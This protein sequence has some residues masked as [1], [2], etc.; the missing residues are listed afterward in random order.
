ML[1]ITSSSLVLCLSVS[2]W[3][4]G[5]GDDDGDGDGNRDSGAQTDS[6][7][8]TDAGGGLPGMDAGRDA[9]L[10]SGS[11]TPPPVDSGT[12]TDAGHVVTDAGGS[13]DAGTPTSYSVTLTSAQ[14]APPCASAATGATGTAS[15]VVS[16]DNSKIDVELAYSGLSGAATAAHIHAGAI[17][18]AGPF[19]LPF[20]A[21]LT[22]PIK[23]TFT[24][25][26]Y[27]APSGA[28]ATFAAFVT[29][30][31]T[32]GAY[33]NVHTAA[34]GAGEIRGQIQ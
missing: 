1:K 34:C 4:I 19:V 16:A 14:G 22:S 15:V 12:G 3:L 11:T 7:T 28:P 18:V 20:A 24:A 30:L 17:G 26:D 33:L 8:H 5:C 10:D 27:A 31:K 21:P 32:G 13:I 29:S 25:A 9:G 23:K 2:A 6:G